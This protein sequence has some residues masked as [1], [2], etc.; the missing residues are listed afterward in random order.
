MISKSGI[1]NL[2]V[3][4]YGSDSI[5]PVFSDCKITWIMVKSTRLKRGIEPLISM[6]HAVPYICVYRLLAE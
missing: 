5:V 1:H 4:Y 3:D 6:E 2:G